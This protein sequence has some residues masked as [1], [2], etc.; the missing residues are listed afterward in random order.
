VPSSLAASGFREIVGPGHAIA[1]NRPFENDTITIVLLHEAFGI[2]KERCKQAPSEAAL[3][4]LER[5]VPIVCQWHESED[6][7]QSAI[8]S[9]I[10]SHT[11]LYID[12]QLVPGTAFHTRGNLPLFVMP[13]VIQECK[14]EN[15]DALSRAIVYYAHFFKLTRAPENDLHYYNYDTRFPSILVTW[16][17]IL[18]S[19]VQYGMGN[20]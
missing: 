20:V 3:A 15:G 4:C 7:Q 18:D 12:K 6:S 9:V 2:F 10:G 17:R 1:C 8:L 19:M 16:L 13:A 14:N 11:G 5:L